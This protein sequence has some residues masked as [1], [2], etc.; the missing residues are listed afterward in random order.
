[1]LTRFLVAI[2]QKKEVE[3]IF[4]DFDE[5]EK[6]REVLERLINKNS[7]ELAFFISKN[8]NQVGEVSFSSVH[9]TTP[10][11]SIELNEEYRGKGLGYLFLK[12]LIDY[13]AKKYTVNHFVYKVFEYNEASFK[14][15]EKLGGKL[16]KKICLADAFDATLI[17]NLGK[18]FDVRTYIIKP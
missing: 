12:T 9:S 6:K 15:A 11:I 7:D 13:V 3:D 8:G 17:K 16:E 5:S 1:M 10:E 18:K 4:C 2:L 14:V